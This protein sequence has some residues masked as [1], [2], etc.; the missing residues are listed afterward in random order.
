MI[1]VVLCGSRRQFLDWCR[2]R[3]INPGDPH[4]RPVA[5]LEDVQK[6][7]GLG[8]PILIEE[9]GTFWDLHTA[10][11]IHLEVEYVRKI[12]EGL[13]DRTGPYSGQIEIL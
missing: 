4:L 8:E 13:P 12:N 10:A 6:L 2:D 3:T 1:T 5:H 7:R 9:T 11:Q